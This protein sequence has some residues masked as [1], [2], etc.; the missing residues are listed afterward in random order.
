MSPPSAVTLIATCFTLVSCSAYSLTLNT[1][2]IFSS[3]TSVCFQRIT[4]R[5]IPVDRTLHNYRC[6]NLFLSP[7]SI[8]FPFPLFILPLF[9][10]ILFYFLLHSLL[11]FFT[12]SFIISPFLS[13]SSIL[14]SFY[15]LFLF[16]S[17]PFPSLS[18]IHLPLFLIFLLI[19]PFTF[20]C[21][22]LFPLFF[23][24]FPTYL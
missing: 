6:E 4:W 19:L 11:F 17:F 1:E 15:S 7:T 16:I 22:L 9:L 12:V 10:L 21:F 20:L 23:F 3:E 5:Y 24:A 2:V 18:S 14:F 13:S 8:S